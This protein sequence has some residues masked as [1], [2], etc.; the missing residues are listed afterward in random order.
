VLCENIIF[1]CCLSEFHTVGELPTA[2]WPVRRILIGLNDT[3][4]P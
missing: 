1:C 3:V 4:Y 2:N